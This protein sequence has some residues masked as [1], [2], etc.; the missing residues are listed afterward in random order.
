MSANKSRRPGIV[1]LGVALS[2]G[3]FGVC[4]IFALEGSVHGAL[5]AA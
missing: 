2:W 1:E 3:D 4:K 5:Q